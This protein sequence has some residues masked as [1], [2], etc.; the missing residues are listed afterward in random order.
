M[1][2]DRVIRRLVRLAAAVALALCAGTAAAQLFVCT[3]SSGRTITADRP[4]ADCADRPVRELRPDG[5]VRRVIEPPMTA[6]QRAARE[7]EA[8]RQV[9]ERERQR[10]QMRRDLSLLETYGSENEIEA[11]RNRALGDRQVLI[12]R[13]T[14]RMDEL[15]RER[16]KLDDETE[17]FTKREMPE[18]LKRALAANNEMVKTQQ[19]VITDTKADMEKVNERYDEE[20]RRFRELVR[21]GAQPAQRPVEGAEKK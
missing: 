8:R 12:E 6:E 1:A 16:K 13:A 10:S 18:K 7:A 17:F 5:S 9:E 3:T 21:S 11:T 4:P 2:P 14:R 15:K 20:T 19:K